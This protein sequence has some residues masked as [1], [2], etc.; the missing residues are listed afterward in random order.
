[1]TRRE[2]KYEGSTERNKRDRDHVMVYPTVDGE[3][4]DR[5]RLRG[6]Y[7]ES[8]EAR[9]NGGTRWRTALFHWVV[10]VVDDG[11][12]R[13]QNVQRDVAASVKVRAAPS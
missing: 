8:S 4:K 5:E 7:S 3:G 9:A 13:N 12:K 1:M 6:P 10:L 2:V 11:D